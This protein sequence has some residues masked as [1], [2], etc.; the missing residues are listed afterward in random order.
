MELIED[1][2]FIKTPFNKAVITIGNFDG[3]HK[4]HQ[5]IF[6]QVIE[7][8]EEIGG[9]SVVMTFDPHP[10]KVLGHNGPPLITRKDQKIEL[11]SATGIDKI[12]CLPFTREFAAISA[13]EFIKD[14][15][16]NQLGMKAIVVG[17]DYSFG[18]NREGNLELMQKAGKQLGFEVLIADWINDTETGSERISSTRIRELVMEG[19]VD[20]TPKFL[21]RFYQIRGKVVKG[22]Q[23]G[24]SKLGFPTANIKLHDELS[25][26]M[27]VY[28][29]TVETQT[30]KFKGVANIGYSPTFDDHIFTIEVHLLDFAGDLYN[31]RIRINMIK[32]LRDE[33][34]FSNLEELSNQIRNDIQLAREILA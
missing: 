9:T 28:A 27:G 12:L 11:I 32:R 3:V 13:Q 33:K 14:L 10:L 15:L 22:R 30:G 20:E 24:G 8:A 5:A 31:T 19:R 4:G 23:R 1:L 7:K 25:P 21:G 26:K 18:R 34:K 16:I 2:K 6:H 29:V 17:L